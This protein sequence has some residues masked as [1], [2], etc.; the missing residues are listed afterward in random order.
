[1]KKML[2]FRNFRQLL[3][4]KKYFPCTNFST[5]AG[6]D[7]KFFLLEYEYVD[8][9]LDKRGP[10]RPRHFDYIRSFVEQGTLIAGG[11]LVPKVDR[12]VIVLRTTTFEK[13]KEFAEGDPY[14]K[15]G[16][17]RRWKASEWMVVAGS[18]LFVAK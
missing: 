3:L 10:V 17:V 6:N 14:V 18:D 5:K 8:G 13:V 16:L 7:V 12:G 4:K 15:E 11:A 2:S 1:M 9:M